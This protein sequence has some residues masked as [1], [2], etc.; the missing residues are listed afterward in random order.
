MIIRQ[1]YSKIDSKYALH[2][3]WIRSR[4]QAN[5]IERLDAKHHAT[6]IDSV[7]Q[8]EN[9]DIAVSGGP[10]NFEVLIYRNKINA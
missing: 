10:L 6:Q 5:S 8:L 4:K 9:G 3:N 1:H 7:I 2:T